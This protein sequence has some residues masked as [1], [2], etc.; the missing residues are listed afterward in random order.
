MNEINLN[1]EPLEERLNLSGSVFLDGADLIIRGTTLDD[2]ISVVRVEG[3]LGVTI[4]EFDH[5]LFS[6]TGKIDVKMFAGDDSL[7]IQLGIQNDTF[8]SAGQGDDVVWGGSGKDMIYGNAGNDVLNGRWGKDVLVGA[9]GRDILRGSLGF[10]TLRGGG[11]Q[12]KLYGGEGNDNLQG[13]DGADLL[14]GQEGRDTLRG[15]SGN[16]NLQGGAGDDLLLDG[17]F[18]ADSIYG[19]AGADLLEGGSGNDR[20]WGDAGNDVLLGELGDDTI[21][22]GIGA[23][24]LDGGSGADMLVGGSDADVILGEGGNDTIYGGTG[25]DDLSGGFGNDEIHGNQGNDSLDGGGNDDILYGDNGDDTLVGGSGSDSLDGGAQ[26]DIAFDRGENLEV[27]IEEFIV[28]LDPLDAIDTGWY[29]QNGGVVNPAGGTTNYV[30]GSFR[31]T[32]YRN[33]SV[34]NTSGIDGTVIS[35]T[36]RMYNLGQAAEGEVNGYRS[37]DSTETYALYEVE[38]DLTGLQNGTLGVNGFTDLGDG[39]F[40]GDVI[41][42]AADNGQFVEIELNTDAIAAINAANG[43]IAFG[44]AVTTLSTPLEFREFIFGTSHERP[45][46]ELVVAIG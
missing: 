29:D 42:S 24:Y 38:S 34:F 40:F 41:V 27:R 16:D 3:E 17:G 39:T 30:A 11:G 1:V 31:N 13:G 4:N 33:F 36:L 20:M 2:V 45:D 12:D 25:D 7:S 19:G 37:P 5:G 23:D 28:F 9:E 6:P 43:E 22:G 32:E 21:N 14:F 44:G 8:I 35:A 46:V 15:G 10:D 18:G 26:Y